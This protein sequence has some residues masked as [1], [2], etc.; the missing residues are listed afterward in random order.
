MSILKYFKPLEK[1]TNQVLLD[2]K[3]PLS[4]FHS[5]SAIKMVKDK[6]S[7]VQETSSSAVKSIANK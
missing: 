5:T 1:T 6:V 2:P 4:K 7:K 3:G